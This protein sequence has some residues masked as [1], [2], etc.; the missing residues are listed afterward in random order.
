LCGSVLPEFRTGSSSHFLCRT[1]A[2]TIEG[3]PGKA[4]VVRSR[5]NCRMVEPKDPRPLSVPQGRFGIRR[6]DGCTPD[7]AAPSQS[8]AG[9]IE[10]VLIRNRG[11]NAN[12]ANGAHQ[13][14]LWCAPFALLAFNSRFLS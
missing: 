6:P 2:G 9:R 5:A 4:A 14:I 11:I 1:G 3:L 13:K 8:Q 7:E 12:N 10:T